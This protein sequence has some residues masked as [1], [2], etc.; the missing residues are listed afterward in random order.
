VVTTLIGTISKDKDFKNQKELMQLQSDL[1]QKERQEAAIDATIATRLAE[2]EVTHRNNIEEIQRHAAQGLTEQTTLVATRDAT[3]A[4]R[5]AQ[6]NRLNNQIEELTREVVRIRDLENTIRD[7]AIQDRD[8]RTE[9]DNLQAIVDWN[10]QPQ[11]NILDPDIPDGGLLA[12]TQI[13]FNVRNRGP[14]GRTVAFF[15]YGVRT[16]YMD[17]IDDLPKNYT[18]EVGLRSVGAFNF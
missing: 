1:N 2:Q 18:I 12:G 6:I 4:E 3:L 16:E 13:T 14:G 9:R 7:M 5:D 11:I 8:M 17:I 15:Y 10:R